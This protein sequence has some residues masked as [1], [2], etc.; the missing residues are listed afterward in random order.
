MAPRGSRGLCSRPWGPGKVDTQNE[1][2]LMHA[3]SANHESITMLDEE[4]AEEEEEILT[5]S[6]EVEIDVAADSGAVAHTTGPDGL[7]GTI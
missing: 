5:T 4:K 3:E 7:P 2:K 1:A 6:E